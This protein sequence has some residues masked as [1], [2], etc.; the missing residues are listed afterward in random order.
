MNLPCEMGTHGKID[1]YH[2]IACI[3][4]RCFMKRL[5]LIDGNSVMYR[6]YFSTAYTGNLMQT[7]NGV[8][9]NA[10]HSF[11]NMMNKALRTFEHTHVLVAFDAGKQTFRHE[12]LKSYKD[13]RA[14]MPD[15]LREQIPLIKKYLD[16]VGISRFE[17]EKY[18]ADDIIGTLACMAE[19]GG[20]ETINILTGDKDLLQLVS[21]KII[22]H[23]M[24][25]GISIIESFTPALVM[26][27][28]EVVPAQIVDLKG[29]MGDTADNLPGVP[30]VGIKTA[31]KALKNFGS[32]DEVIAKR[33]E[34][35][36]K[37]GENLRANVE[38]VQLCYEMAKLYLQVEDVPT[39]EQL[40]CK[41]VQENELWDFFQEMELNSFLK[42]MKKKPRLSKTIDF[43][44]V[45]DVSVLDAK[46][47]QD[48]SIHVEID[49]NNYHQ[50]EIFGIAVVNQ[51]EK[52][53]V[54]FEIAKVSTKFM[55]FLGSA[56]I[57]KSIFDFKKARVALMWQGL[58]L[59][60]IDSD[61][62]L[63]VYVLNPNYADNEFKTI[64]MHFGYDHVFY[65]EDVY[66]KGVAREIPEQEMI[67]THAINIA[68][69]ISELDAR[70]T[71]EL[72]N[73]DQYFLYKELELPLAEILAEM[74]YT[75]MNLSI[76]TLESIGNDLSERSLALE[77]TIYDLV[78]E[79]FKINST[80]QLGE[81]LFERLELPVVKKTKTGYSTSIEV[82]EKLKHK[83]E[84]IPQIIEYRSITKLYSTYI[85]GLK[86]AVLDDAKV[87]TIFKQ[88]FTQTGRL[89]STEPNLQNIPVR[90]E[91]GRLIRKAFVPSHT[92]SVLLGIDYS[93]I[94]LRVLA[95]ISGTESLIEAFLKDEDI[96]AK[97]AMDVFA[98]NK[99][100]MTS[101]LRRAAK[102]INF[103]II[104]GMS[105][106]GL[107][108]TL[109][110]TQKEARQYIKSYLETYDG[111]KKYM[112]ETVRLAKK[113]GYVETLFNRRRYLPEIK[114]NNPAIRAFGE[115]TAMNAPVQ[116]TA[117]DIIK[118][119]M[120]TIDK[121]MKA[122]GVKSKM[123]LQ[124][125]DELLFDVPQDEIELMTKLAS[126]AM[127]QVT[128]LKVPLKVDASYGA[129][130]YDAK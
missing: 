116:G 42:N 37:F 107:A 118:L 28:F 76:E 23:M 51:D 82:L 66:G 3:H 85:E 29:L 77:S 41:D 55:D 113:N 61:L 88:A 95:H 44:I 6:A 70:I 31:L 84:I 60:G 11:V 25:K 54:P 122:A 12:K 40:Q 83:H 43:E 35:T 104:Y 91:E 56:E 57:K 90:L 64:A 103:G 72:R 21:D 74:E 49:G 13:G 22:V 67:A 2:I 75:G 9:T 93:Q 50:A 98:L 78:G 38:Q 94:E 99:D 108:E 27:K 117:A 39:L 71:K 47:W 48:S 100:E 112:D 58:E 81:I 120:I 45:S 34:I 126:E 109:K 15:E 97:T 65:D 52:Y 4:T 62:L 16:L 130:W 73:V 105:P 5:L 111:I 68:V 18:E 115:R 33:E 124:V 20:F 53:Y 102:A 129:T 36:G 14:A 79:E 32:F 24:I 59:R 101:E 119:A 125:H 19:S 128:N 89:S 26:E 10:L 110:I 127:E 80:K 87:H 46:V 8:C 96:H 63:K 7:S 121:E 106:F 86:K 30:G 123:I 69:A 114:H 17:T 1:V 92:D